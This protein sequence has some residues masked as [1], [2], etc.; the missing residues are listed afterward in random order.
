M[1]DHCSDIMFTELLVIIQQLLRIISESAI[2]SFRQVAIIRRAGIV[3]DKRTGCIGITTIIIICIG[4]KREG[5][6][7]SQINIC[8][9]TGN[10]R[11]TGRFIRTI[12]V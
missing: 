8:I 1:T 9:T 5:Q 3:I 12:F 7:L 4:I 2:R 10:K 11:V 6:I